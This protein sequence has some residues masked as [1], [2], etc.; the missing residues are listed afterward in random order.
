MPT[1]QVPVHG[2]PHNKSC[3]LCLLAGFLR[4]KTLHKSDTAV[5]LL[6]RVNPNHER[7]DYSCTFQEPCLC[8]EL[9]DV[10]FVEVWVVLWT[11]GWHEPGVILH[12]GLPRGVC[13]LTRSWVNYL[14]IWWST[15]DDTSDDSQRTADCR[16]R[17]IHCFGISV[18]IHILLCRI[19]H[20]NSVA[21]HNFVDM[22]LKLTYNYI[23][24]NILMLII[25]CFIIFCWLHKYLF[26]RVCSILFLLC[27]ICERTT[28]ITTIIYNYIID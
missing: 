4:T 2:R 12:R 17:T 20:I 25:K 13:W 23:I 28:T 18:E 14:N 1:S 10:V 15:T 11:R 26:M 9:I 24:Y 5:V 19:Q 16:H 3:L 21:I 8:G 22:L 6:S 27:F 7:W